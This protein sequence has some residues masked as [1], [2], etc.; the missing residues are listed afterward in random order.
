MKRLSYANVV[1]SIALFAALGGSA[2]A[3]ATVTGKDV[4]NNSLTGKDVRNR[5]LTQKDI[6]A[7]SVD[8]RFALV[9]EMGNIVEQSGGFRVVSK[10][11]SNGQ[12][13]SNPNIYID[14]GSSLRGRGLS[15]TTAIQN[16][17]DTDGDEMPDPNFAGDVAVG[18]CN[19]DAINC[20]PEGTN[21][22]EVLVVR[23]QT[24]PANDLTTSAAPTRFYV[25]VT[26]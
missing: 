23:A 20:V 15:A 22:D 4:R 13:E 24:R 10:P 8:T 3:V 25:L 5:S 11:G 7:G 1:A 21:E 14:T 9:D 17:V 12:P 18:R 6:R 26:P 2:Y 16:Q 19:T